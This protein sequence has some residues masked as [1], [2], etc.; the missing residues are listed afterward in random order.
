MTFHEEVSFCRSRE[1][2]IGARL[3]EHEAPTASGDSLDE[4]PSPE[5]EREESK[6]RSDAP[7]K[8]PIEKLLENPPVKRRLAWCR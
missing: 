3:E 1:T 8:E 2:S 6:E 7:A 4:P 5:G